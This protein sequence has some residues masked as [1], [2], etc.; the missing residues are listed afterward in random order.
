VTDASRHT[1]RRAATILEGSIAA[2]A[3]LV[4]AGSLGI[5]AVMLFDPD[6][7]EEWTS[8][9]RPVQ[10][11]AELDDDLLDDYAG[12]FAVAHN[13]GD[14][15]AATL[16]AVGHGADVIEVDVVSLDGRLYAA[17]GS[18]PPFVGQSFFRGPSLDRVWSASAG[19]VAI[20][21]DLKES[22][23]AFVDLVL[24]FL[25][26][27]REQRRVIVVSGDTDVL[28]T[29]AEH[30]PAVLRFLSIGNTGQFSALQRDEA[31]ATEIDGISIRHTLL[32]DGRA[33]WVEERDLFVL[34]WTVN[35][36]GRVNELAGLGVDAVTTDNLA[37][38]ALLGESR[39]GASRLDA[40][41]LQPSRKA[42]GTPVSGGAAPQ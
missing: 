34:A 18:P 10:F 32:D 1:L 2:V 24:R 27:R 17:H 39:V 31:L 25:A 38:M 29:F 37:I 42:E 21:L 20:K 35:D 7:A 12:M 22:S 13:S 30:E 9:L 4:I 23:P 15:I 26:Q 8:G 36:M 16:D 40:I 6:L 41:R 11:Y 28:R 14:S 3:V 5:L 19:A 33:A